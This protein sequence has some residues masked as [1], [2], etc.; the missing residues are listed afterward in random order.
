[1]P[2]RAWTYWVKSGIVTGG[3]YN[4]HCGCRPYSIPPID[5]QRLSRLLSSVVPTP[6]CVKQCDKPYNETYEHDKHY[7]MVFDSEI[8]NEAVSGYFWNSF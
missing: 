2:D 5:D 7:G 4:S 1:M 3:D 6:E 8:V